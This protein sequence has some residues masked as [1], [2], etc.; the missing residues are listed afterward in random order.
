MMLV[1]YRSSE[2]QTVRQEDRINAL[3]PD[4]ARCGL[5]S[6]RPALSAAAGAVLGA[7]LGLVVVFA[8]EYLESSIVRRR[9][10]VERVSGLPVLAVIPGGEAK[11]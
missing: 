1:R 8:L 6:P 9:E 10:D 7:V 2:N 3:L 5:Q 11:R 4:S